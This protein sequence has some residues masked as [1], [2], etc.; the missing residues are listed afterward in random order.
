MR[1]VITLGVA[2]AG[3]SLFGAVTAYGKINSHSQYRET[4]ETVVDDK[5]DLRVPSD[6]LAAYQMLGIWAVAEGGGP[7]SRELHVVYASPGTIAAYRRGGDF[8]EGAVLVKEVF[9]TV[10]QG[11]TAGTV[12]GTGALAGWFVIVKDSGSR[13]P[14]NRL[15]GEGWGQAWFDVNSPQKAVWTDHTTACRVPARQSGWICTHAIRS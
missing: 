14:G 15:W 9:R 13:F 12:S 5:G 1:N 11:M 2:L 10:T 8:P 3:L 7:D 4:T 6:Y